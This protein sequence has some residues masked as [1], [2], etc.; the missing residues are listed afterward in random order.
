LSQETV[1][2]I[3]EQ[4]R[5]NYA[6]QP[7]SKAAFVDLVTTDQPEAPSYFTYDAV[8]NSQERPTLDETLERVSA[9]T[10]DRVLALQAAG[11]QV[12]D[13]RDP[14]EFAAAHLAGSV[15]IGLGGQYATWAGTVLTRE[16]PI[17]IVADPGR[18]REAA[19]RLGRIGFDQVA[20]YLEDGLHSVAPRPDLLVSTERVS[21]QVAA[22]RVEHAP[23]GGAPVIVDVRAP[24][25]RQEKRIAGSV[26]I[27][28][29]HLA[30][31]LAE[32][33]ADRPLLVHCAGGYRSSIASSLLQRHGF[34]K[35]AEIAGGITAWDAARLPVEA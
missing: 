2:T 12:L 9:L 17:V 27:P 31:R 20:G 13:T 29:N 23:A 19:M 14:A 6:L 35:V 10:L 1:S 16:Q 7:M 15:N 28:L 18:E 22:D 26:G 30:E 33:P 32:L 8:L 21:A 34:T 25:E 3:G 4:R 5:A 24:S 11:A